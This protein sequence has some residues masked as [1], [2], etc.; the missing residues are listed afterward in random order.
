MPALIPT[1]FTGTITYLGHVPDREAALASAPLAEMFASFAGAKTE[2]RGGLTRPSCS[3]VLSQYPRG[4]EIRN[5]R[6]FSVVCQ[7]E[8]ARI[9]GEM[10]IDR[11]APEWLGVSLMISGLP[12][13]SHIPPSSRLQ[14]Q[15][16]T[17]LTADMLNRPCMLPAPVIERF[18]PGKG[19]LF[20]TAAK[21]LRGITA[22]VER[23]GLLSVG[24]TITLHIPDQ[25]AWVGPVYSARNQPF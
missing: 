7:E 5:T 14:T 12:D 11:L 18:C 21:G 2:S 9:A 20:K 25:R 13:F 3:R 8:L 24:D 15:R 4:T 19:K 22:W 23:E 16:G 6:Q 17:T 10:G 1:E